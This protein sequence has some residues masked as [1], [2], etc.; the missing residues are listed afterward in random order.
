V[1]VNARLAALAARALRP[2]HEGVARV[3]DMSLLDEWQ[4]REEWY[5][6]RLLAEFPRE[7]TTVRAFIDERI[8]EWRRAAAPT[9]R[10]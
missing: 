7:L 10:G 1:H 5:P 3:I 8:A 6:K 9:R 4:M 2:W